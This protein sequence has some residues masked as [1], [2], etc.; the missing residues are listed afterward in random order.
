MNPLNIGESAAASKI[1]FRGT[2]RTET[3]ARTLERVQ[4]ILPA[5]GI[6]GIANVTGLDKIG[7]PVVMTCRPNSRSLSVFQGKGVDLDA[8]RAC[9]VMEACDHPGTAADRPEESPCPDHHHARRV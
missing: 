4:G 1:Y 5:M 7:I 6:T 9:G 8:A 2:E 3:P